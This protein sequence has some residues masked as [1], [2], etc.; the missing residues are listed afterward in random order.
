LSL[1]MTGDP[2]KSQR[3]MAALMKM[4]KLVIADLENA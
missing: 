1:L 3:V 2:Q 4:K